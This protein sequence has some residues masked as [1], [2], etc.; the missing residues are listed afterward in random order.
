MRNHSFIQPGAFEPELIAAMAEA[1]EA[2]CKGSKVAC[3]AS[4]AW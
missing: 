1:F 4:K 2:A 3:D